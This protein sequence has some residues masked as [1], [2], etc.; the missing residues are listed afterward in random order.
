[1]Y[2]RGVS[3]R[4]PSNSMM[5]L[6]P[7]DIC[8]LGLPLVSQSAI[9]PLVSQSVISPQF[10]PHP[11]GLHKLCDLP[12]FFHSDSDQQ[13]DN[14]NS[15]QPP[16]STTHFI[17]MLPSRR[18]QPHI[19]LCMLSPAA[20]K[21]S[22][23]TIFLLYILT[24]HTMP[25]TLT[26]NILLVLSDGCTEFQPDTPEAHQQGFHTEGRSPQPGGSQP[27]GH[28]LLPYTAYPQHAMHLA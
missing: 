14:I 19:V 26:I 16:H 6:G 21:V 7:C 4:I 17:H 1:M 5:S 10:R 3:P 24:M 20:S 12:C 2:S 9:S 25:H 22:L 23:Y 27:G 11:H 15:I 28:P 8:L 13:K 18:Y